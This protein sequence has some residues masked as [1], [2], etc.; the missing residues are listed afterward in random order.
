V[1]EININTLHT[2]RLDKAVEVETIRD[3]CRLKDERLVKMVVL[4]NVGSNRPR[5]RPARR[6][7]DDITDWFG[8]T[9]PEAVELALDRKKWRRMTGLNGDI[10]HE[11]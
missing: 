9:L 8:C 1:T 2:S 10:C 7:S 6:R 5:G 11:F 4:R 3:I